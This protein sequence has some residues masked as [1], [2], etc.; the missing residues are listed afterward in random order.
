[1]NI[2]NIVLSGLVMT[3]LP[4]GAIAEPDEPICPCL[5]STSIQNWIDGMAKMSCVT[6][7]DTTFSKGR[8]GVLL[9]M[10][11]EEVGED[12]IRMAVTYDRDDEAWYNHRCDSAH[13]KVYLYDGL[14]PNC[15][16]DEFPEWQINSLTDEELRD[17]MKVLRG[18]IRDL[19]ALPACP[20][21]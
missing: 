19:E 1:M 9:T 20:P 6:D 7:L 8:Q 10:A 16:H 2:R 3:F 13:G 17:C 15:Q 11:R 5:D 18:L 12:C 4:L 14:Y 21:E